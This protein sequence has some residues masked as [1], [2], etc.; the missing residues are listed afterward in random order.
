MLFFARL[1]HSPRQ[2]INIVW[3]CVHVYLH[4]AYSAHTAMRLYRVITCNSRL[5]SLTAPLSQLSQQCQF[6]A[7]QITLVA[8][9][10][11]MNEVFHPGG[12]GTG[13]ASRSCRKWP[14][15]K[16]GETQVGWMGLAHYYIIVNFY[17]ITKFNYNI[18]ANTQN[19]RGTWQSRKK[20]KKKR[21]MRKENQSWWRRP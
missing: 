4:V 10:W 19:M 5:F 13:W 1:G 11:C 14:I 6:A 2:L 20:K 18:W 21:A 16:T 3:A 7:L 15:R 9:N 12:W 8:R 17:F